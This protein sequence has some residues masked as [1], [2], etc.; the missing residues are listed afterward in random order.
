MDWQA[1]LDWNEQYNL[2]GVTLGDDTIIG[3]GFS[4]N[5]SFKDGEIN[6]GSGRK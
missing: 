1:V 5:K 2:P 6:C 4:G 3:A